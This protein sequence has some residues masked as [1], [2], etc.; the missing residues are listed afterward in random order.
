MKANIMANLIIHRGTNEIGGSAIEINNN[1]TKL[2]FDF[3]IPLESM[4]KE[5]YN[6]EDYKLPIN[7][8]YKNEE[9]QFQAVFL[10]HAHADHF[11]L[12]QLINKNIPIYVNK[13]T[14]DILSKIVPLLPKSSTENLNLNIIS[15]EIEID[16][17][18]IKMH[19]VDHSVAGA[20]AYEI[21]TDNKTI[22]YTGDLRFHGRAN[23]KSCEFK[24]KISNPD[25]LI[26]EGTTLGRTE[27]NIVYEKDLEDEFIK[28]F[29]NDKL[30]LVQFS[31][32]NLDRFI[33]VYRACLIAKK[34][35]VIDP[36]TC[37]V[38]DVY[39]QLSKNIPQYDWNNIRVNFANSKI[40]R[41]MASTKLLYKYKSKKIS[42]KEII[43]NPEQYV[44]KGNGAINEQLLNSID[45]DKIIIVYSM[46]K[47]YL[48]KPNQFDNYKDIIIPIHTSGH[49]YIKDLQSFAN[50]I[51]PK[52][53]IPVHTEC[54]EKY[55][56]YFNSNVIN[57]DDGQKL[58]L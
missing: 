10:T 31:S 39:S 12:M 56:E 9:P 53:I 4:N 15:D 13:I 5:N 25:Y 47:G 29:K 17:I 54:K 19:N 2:L 36:Y 48:D 51:N 44:V 43:N 49:A 37:F 14:Y 21:I 35:L 16:N 27:Q 55:S 6:V 30:P 45:R 46:W 26:M 42:V 7:G 33:T 22:I 50:D 24:R 32:Q 18:K 8:L 41:K 38:L 20:C 23:W 57:L 1:K 58:C 3:G 40:N 52:N 34:T 11:G 28:I